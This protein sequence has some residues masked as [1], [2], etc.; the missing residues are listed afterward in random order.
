MR[1]RDSSRLVV[2]IVLLGASMFLV[3]GAAPAPREWGSV[4]GRV[5]WAEQQIPVNPPA[6]RAAAPVK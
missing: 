1:S 3:N 6:L 5:V 4:K 2:A